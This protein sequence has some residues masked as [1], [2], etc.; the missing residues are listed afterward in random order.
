[1]M[2][3]YAQEFG[4]TLTQLSWAK[5]TIVPGLIS[6]ITLPVII[7][8]LNPPEI[9]NTPGA[10]QFA[11]ERLKAMGPISIN[12]IFMLSTLGLLLFLWMIGDKF[13][14][15]ATSAA[16]LGLGLL[17]VGGVLTWE[18][19]LSEKTAWDTFIWLTTLIMMTSFL[20]K[21]GMISWFSQH[22]Q[23][24]VF[25]Y[26]WPAALAILL[27]VFYYS[28]YFFASLTA[29][30]TSL[31]SAFTAVAIACG[32]PPILAC[33]MFAFVATLSG[34]TTHY[35]TGCGVVYFGTGY[36]SFSK[37]WTMGAIIGFM[38]MLVWCGIGP[39]WWKFIGIW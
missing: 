30:I 8:Y 11:T 35:G 39:V 12:E 22:I 19:I 5:A 16:F 10:K 9:K 1:M 15:D 18:D 37:W 32:A 4:V 33:L 34:C 36:V 21:F 13:G 31:Y 3:D 25:G 14:V 24:M 20:A 28:H 7:Y 2:V 23:N 38:H 27:A 26:S 6:L 29:H 17:L